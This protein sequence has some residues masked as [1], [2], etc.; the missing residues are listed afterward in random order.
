M[1]G[2]SDAQNTSYPDCLSI[3]DVGGEGQGAVN[4]E[5]NIQPLNQD[6]RMDF[7]EPGD[8]NQ[9]QPHQVTGVDIPKRSASYKPAWKTASEVR[10]NASS[11]TK[12]RSNGS[13]QILKQNISVQI[14]KSLSSPQTRSFGSDSSMDLSPEPPKSR[15]THNLTEKRYRTRL[16]GQF[17]TLLSILPSEL[18]AAY[19]RSCCFGAENQRISK[20]EVLILAKEHI[21]AMEEKRIELEKQNQALLNEIARL[22]QAWDGI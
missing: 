12:S 11:N 14:E 5:P 8:S 21:E 15:I 4:Y 7:D 10:S 20:S 19:N 2:S 22:K 13:R 17:E 16:N 6:M 9:F 18:V 3:F 1:T